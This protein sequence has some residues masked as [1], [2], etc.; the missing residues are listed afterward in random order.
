[1]NNKICN[2]KKSRILTESKKKTNRI[3]KS[4][5]VVYECVGN[6]YNHNNLTK[7]QTHEQGIVR[8]MF[9]VM[10][11]KK[12]GFHFEVRFDWACVCVFCMLFVGISN[13]YSQVEQTQN[14]ENKAHSITSSL[15]HFN[16]AETRLISYYNQLNAIKR[17]SAK[18]NKSNALN[19]WRIENV[20][21]WCRMAW[22]TGLWAVVA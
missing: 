13:W 7:N 17:D 10:R 4:N 8:C 9:W 2:K 18:W 20:K 22:M 15:H 1:M 12:S 16:C 3:K 6:G 5:C 19:S 14:D 11:W 21:R